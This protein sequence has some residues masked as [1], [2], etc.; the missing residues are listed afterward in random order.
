MLSY[1]DMAPFNECGS[2][3]PP[4]PA[5]LISCMLFSAATYEEDKYVSMIFP[6][7]R[8]HVQQSDGC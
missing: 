6:G 8:D 5:K 1:V 2:P 3:Y 4:L 7:R